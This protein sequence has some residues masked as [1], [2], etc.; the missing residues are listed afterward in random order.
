[1]DQPLGAFLQQ[2]TDTVGRTSGN[3]LVPPYGSGPP[4][5]MWFTQLHKELPQLTWEFTDSCVLRFRP[6]LRSNPLGELI[7]L[8]KT[9][10]SMSTWKNS[11]FSWLGLHRCFRPSRFSSSQRAYMSAFALTWSSRPLLISPSRWGFGTSI[12]ICFIFYFCMVIVDE[13]HLINDIWF[14]FWLILN[15]QIFGM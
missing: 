5:Q 6:P 12:T 9:G 15:V 11:R 4:A 2:A 10:P 8:K 7:T 14:W 13:I 1:M 3:R